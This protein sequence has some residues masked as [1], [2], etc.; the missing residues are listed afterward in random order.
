[1]IKLRQKPPPP[2]SVPPPPILSEDSS[3]SRVISPAVFPQTCQAAG[4][5]IV[6]LISDSFNVS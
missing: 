2:R 4:Q 1:M 6:L 5:F 3:L